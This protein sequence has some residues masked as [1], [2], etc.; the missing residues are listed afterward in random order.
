M[1]A[2]A[3]AARAGAVIAMVRTCRSPANVTGAVT[4]LDPRRAPRVVGDPAP[5]TIAPRPLA[6]VER[7]PSP[8][9]VAAV[10]PA[11]VGPHPGSAGLVR[12]EIHAHHRGVRAPDA[13]VLGVLDPLAVGL[14][15]RVDLGIGDSTEDVTGILRIRGRL[16]RGIAVSARFEAITGIDLTTWRTVHDHRLGSEIRRGGRRGVLAVTGAREE[17]DDGSDWQATHDTSIVQP[18]CLTTRLHI[19]SCPGTRPGA[20]TV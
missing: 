19:R 8:V 15:G 7:Q 1:I 2:D 18:A 12:C 16:D 17:R 9:P 5:V 6:V 20:S 13:A 10:R 4:P 14:Q 3:W 11:V